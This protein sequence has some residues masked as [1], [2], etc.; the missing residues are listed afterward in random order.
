VLTGNARHYPVD[1]G[2]EVLSPAA[3]LTRLGG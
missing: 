1:L 3:L 2:F